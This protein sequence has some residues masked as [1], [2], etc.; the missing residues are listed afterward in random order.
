MI[1]LSELKFDVPDEFS[2]F[3]SSFYKMKKQITGDLVAISGYPK[4]I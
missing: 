1:V 2:F 3:C 4:N